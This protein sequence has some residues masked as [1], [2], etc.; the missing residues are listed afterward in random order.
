MEISIIIPH[1]NRVESVI[2]C[3]NSIAESDYPQDNYEVI[4]VD[5]GSD[6]DIMA[7][8]EY[9]K[10]K[11][12]YFYELGM[13]SGTASV[14]RN[15]ALNFA[16]GKYA[17]FIDSDDVVTPDFI[18]GLMNVANKHD[19]DTVIGKKVSVQGDVKYFSEIVEDVYLIDLEKKEDELRWNRLLYRDNFVTGKL[20]RMSIIQKFGIRFPEKLRLNEDIC[21]A[22]VFWM[23]I[24]TAGLSAQGHYFINHTP[25]SL[26]RSVIPHGERAFECLSAILSAT[27]RVPEDIVPMKKKDKVIASFIK[28]AIDGILPDRPDLVARMRVEFVRYFTAL[29]KSSHIRKTTIEFIDEVME[30][31]VVA[32][33]GEL[34]EQDITTGVAVHK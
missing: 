18:S 33:E 6:D 12:Y 14:P 11:N 8:R 13:N 5:D 15:F 32:I 23:F 22:K 34:V 10:I 9:S 28:G 7:A 24:K 4:F 2:N 17:L 19:C 30:E 27:L 20:F 25:G 21:Y 31:E 29:K 16:Q 1:Y 3:L 26:M